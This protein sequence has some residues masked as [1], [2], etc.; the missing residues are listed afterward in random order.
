M[1]DDTLDEYDEAQMDEHFRK[2][3]LWQQKKAA[4]A[5]AH[6]TKEVEEQGFAEIAE[7]FVIGVDEVRRKAMSA[8]S[9]E[10]I[11]EAEED[12]KAHVKSYL[13]RRVG[14]K[15][16]K[17]EGRNRPVQDAKGRFSSKEKMAVEKAYVEK[18][19]ELQ[20]KAQAGQRLSDD[21]ILS[22]MPRLM[23]K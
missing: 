5:G 6:R 8:D 21:D 20:T 14:P 13:R 12:Y 4:Q 19:K 16:G 22:I 2:L 3:Q 15:V 10:D 18:M 17:A 23:G 7:E 9:Q 1:A 11:K